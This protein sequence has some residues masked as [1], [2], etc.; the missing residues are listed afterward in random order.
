MSLQGNKLIVTGA[1]RAI[2]AAAVTRFVTEGASVLA[3]DFD[4]SDL[5]RLTQDTN[6][7]GTLE[8]RSSSVPGRFVSPRRSLSPTSER[9]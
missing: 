9:V 4:E 1:A 7:P 6:R 3:V 5:N 8:I 2:G